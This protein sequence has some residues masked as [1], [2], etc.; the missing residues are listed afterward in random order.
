MD[1]QGTWV[2]SFPPTVT[3][4]WWRTSLRRLG[5]FYPFSVTLLYYQSTNK[6]LSF[7][8]FFTFVL[9]WDVKPC[10]RSSE[11]LFLGVKKEEEQESGLRPL[12]DGPDTPGTRRKRTSLSLYS[13][14]SFGRF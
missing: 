1:T 3:E 13:P 6:S 12:P 14:T 4:V 9:V 8:F 2:Q 11:F 5:L 10:F 7:V